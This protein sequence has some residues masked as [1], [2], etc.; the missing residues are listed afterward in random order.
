MLSEIKNIYVP[1]LIYLVVDTREILIQA[2]DIQIVMVY[3]KTN[4]MRWR[5][6]L[7]DIES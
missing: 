6:Q 3:E 4:T 5:R 2:D 7:A 1:A